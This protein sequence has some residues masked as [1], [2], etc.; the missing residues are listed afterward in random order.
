MPRESRKTE[1]TQ[2]LSRLI[3][4]YKK[5]SFWSLLANFDVTVGVQMSFNQ[6]D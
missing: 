6:I 4:N 1:K 3:L 5:E 2:F